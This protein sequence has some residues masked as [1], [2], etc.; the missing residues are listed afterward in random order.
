M[1][2]CVVSGSIEAPPTPTRISTSCLCQGGGSVPLLPRA[3]N[4]SL[5]AGLSRPSDVEEGVTGWWRYTW[6]RV[7]AV[8]V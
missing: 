2:L 4:G 3:L 8:Q 5:R 1:C 6:D 7:E